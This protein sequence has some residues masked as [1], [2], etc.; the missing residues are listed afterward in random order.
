[1]AIQ[2]VGDPLVLVDPDNP[3]AARPYQGLHAVS[4]I[5]T[6]LAVP[7]VAL[8][9]LSP[10][11]FANLGLIAPAI[12][13]LILLAAFIIFVHGVFTVGRIAAVSFNPAKRT[14][15]V[16]ESGMFSR[17]VTTLRFVEVSGL[18]MDTHYD[19][20]GYG[21]ATCELLLRDGQ[22]IALPMRPTPQDVAAVRAMLGTR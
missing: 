17:R 10:R 18:Q 19:R 7:F 11:S 8:A 20:D 5:L 15:E 22:S 9:V 12:M 13:L 16:V 14:V 1:M 4:P 6:G 3:D 2:A 21:Y